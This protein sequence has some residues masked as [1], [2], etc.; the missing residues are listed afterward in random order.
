MDFLGA[1][2]AVL[3][4]AGLLEAATG[5]AVAV[6]GIEPGF[7][8]SDGWREP[9]PDAGLSLSDELAAA[10]VSDEPSPVDS[11]AGAVTVEGE[12]STV[13]ADG[14]GRSF[15]SC[16]LRNSIFASSRLYIVT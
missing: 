8:G 7:G 15:S 6:G 4:V 9:L 1:L 2:D 16:F 5:V 14:G 12:E 13:A 10:S 11:A 3:V